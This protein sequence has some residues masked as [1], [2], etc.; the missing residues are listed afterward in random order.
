M[1]EKIVQIT[2]GNSEIKE[3]QDRRERSMYAVTSNGRILILV[4]EGNSQKWDV[5]TVPALPK[6]NRYP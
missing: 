4:D 6:D 3:A 2:F 1:S 5:L